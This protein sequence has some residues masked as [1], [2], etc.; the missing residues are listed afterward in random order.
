MKYVETFLEEIKLVVQ[1]LKFVII[2]F[3]IQFKT[4]CAPKIRSMLCRF[5]SRFVDIFRQ[6]FVEDPAKLLVEQPTSSILDPAVQLP[7]VN[8]AM[9]GTILIQSDWLLLFVLANHTDGIAQQD[10]C[11]NNC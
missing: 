2:L 1:N 8:V 9:S 7:V 3:Q 4:V 5:D 11:K 6:Q 10:Y